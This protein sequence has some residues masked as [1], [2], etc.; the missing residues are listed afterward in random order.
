MIALS[1]VARGEV[2]FEWVSSMDLE[3]R[4]DSRHYAVHRILPRLLNR[5]GFR[6]R[7]S[8]AA[9]RSVHYP[10]REW[11]FLKWL[12]TRPDITAVHFQE[13]NFWLPPLLRAVRR[14]GKQT[15]YTAHYIRPHSYP[16]LLPRAL[17]D[18]RHFQ[19]C[20]LCDGVFVLSSQLRDELSQAMGP[21]HPQIRIAPH[22][23]WTVGHPREVPTMRERLARKRLLFFGTI[24][25]DKGLD[26]LLDAMPQLSGFG[27]TIAGAPCEAGYFHNE[28]MPRV[29]RLQSAGHR[30][31]VIDR[32]VPDEQAASLFASHSALVLPYTK[33][34][35]AQ[36]GVVF[37]AL[38]HEI[39]VVCSEVGGL[40]EVMESFRIGTTIDE[41][42]VIAL[43]G[44][45]RR[46]C[47]EPH[48][49]DLAGEIREAKDHFSWEACARATMAGYALTDNESCLAYA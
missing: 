14:L 46:L 49:A 17:W 3:D 44:A 10:Y 26:L 27:L 1:Q 25:R 37:L 35:T 5:S 18:K 47:C 15:F 45:I 34:F 33:D 23:V 24:R 32:F 16:P 43:V 40:G 38:A 12:K 6:T 36:S 11:R 31:D 21:S 13:F 9:S 30:I 22:G 4:F 2:E 20:R 39:P 29:R 48:L 8:W 41:P 28:V 7:L 42:S 19:A